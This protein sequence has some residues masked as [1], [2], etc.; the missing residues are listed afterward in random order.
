MASNTLN[1]PKVSAGFDINAEFRS[2]MHELG[3][4]PE[5]TGGSITFVGEDPIFPTVHRLGACISIPIMAGAAGVANIWRQRTGRGQD[6]TLDLRKA[7]HGIN[8]MYKFMPTINGFPYQLPYWINPSYQIDN[9]MGFDLYRTRDGR[10]FLPTG[11][12]PGLLNAMCSFLRCGPDRD[13]ITEAV[14]KWDADELDEAAAEAG[15][16]FAIVRTPEEWAAHPQG[17]YLADKPLVEIVKIGDSDPEPFA[18]AARPLSGLRVLAVTHVIAGNVMARTLAE[19]GAEVLQ[20]AHPEEFENEGLMQDPCAGFTSSA[21]LDLKQPEGL[22]RAYELA[23][24]ADVFVEN[25][26]GRKIANLG[27]S[28][29]EL[30]ARRPGII[31]ASD[32]AYSHDGPWADRGGFDMEALCVTGFTTEEG[33]PEQPK[34]PPTYVMNDF[35]AG[36]VGAAG[37]QAALI[38]RAK[39]G[40]SYHVRVNLAR[41][42]MWFNSLGT[43]D[44]DTPGTG[45]QHQLLAPDT[46]TAQTPYGEL[47]RLAPPVQFS[48]TKPY[49]RDPVLVVRGSS[50]PAWTTV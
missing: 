24:D 16:V 7:I 1:T 40:G 6:L 47:V 42:A 43:F 19:H 25:Y 11:A 22:R 46:I 14:S 29:E 23:A 32:K 13:Q 34:F 27:M 31:Y 10:L 36:Y 48:E 26:R 41:C 30:A 45:E 44:N 35:I 33:T 37:I 12:Y 21:W 20:L 49:W 18:A 15:L 5:D 2:V 9:P 39:E 3:L 8:P 50:K 28:P 4:S 17:K 38:R